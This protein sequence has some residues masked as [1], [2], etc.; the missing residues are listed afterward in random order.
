MSKGLPNKSFEPPQAAQLIVSD[1]E[2]GHA[3]SKITTR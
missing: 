3:G 2:G 1:H